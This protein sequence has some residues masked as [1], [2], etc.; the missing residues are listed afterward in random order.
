MAVATLQARHGLPISGQGCCMRPS[1]RPQIA[2]LPR[3]AAVVA[4]SVSEVAGQLPQVAL[5][6]CRASVLATQLSASSCCA[7][8]FSSTDGAAAGQQRAWLRRGGPCS[9]ELQLKCPAAG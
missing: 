2:S 5:V 4:E 6:L 9:P 7:G 1:R 8:T 3:A